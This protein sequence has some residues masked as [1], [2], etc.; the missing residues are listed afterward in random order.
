MNSEFKAFF[1]LLL[2]LILEPRTGVLIGLLLVAAWSDYKTGR[3]PNILVFPGMVLGLAYNTAY[4][5]FLDAT[6]P[7]AFEGMGIALALMLPFYL[8]RT[9][10]AGDVKLI[11]MSGAFLGFPSVLWA[12]LAVFLA[13][14]VLS[15]A[16]VIRHGS[17][18]RAFSNIAGMLLSA[19]PGIARPWP[20][21]TM[22]SQASVGTLPY[23]IAIAAG[24]IA[25]LVLHQLGY[26][27]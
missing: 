18:R 15:L 23:G 9:I 11:A 10:G 12:T 1:E 27:R 20:L 6:F 24:T 14:G 13:G 5:P 16:Y 21:L 26:V 17:L 8:L 4:P 25:Y 2:M 22:N 7:W 19:L 3:I